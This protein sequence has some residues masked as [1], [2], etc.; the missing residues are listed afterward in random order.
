MTHSQTD[1]TKG[2]LL[3]LYKVHTSTG[4]AAAQV[5]EQA[6]ALQQ[7]LT[8]ER[9]QFTNKYGRVGEDCRP[10]AEIRNNSAKDD[11]TYLRLASGQ[12]WITFLNKDYYSIS[13]HG[14]V[15]APFDATD[16]M[17]IFPEGTAQNGY[18]SCK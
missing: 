10:L 17:W 5:V 12:G 16:I 3:S 7:Q 1:K 11:E 18:R 15:L 6:S 13:C 2:H 9:R 4:E 8:I 14:G